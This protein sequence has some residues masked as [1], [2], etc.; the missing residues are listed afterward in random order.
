MSSIPPDGLSDD[1]V[2]EVLRRYRRVVVVGMS[3]S[4]DKPGHFVPQ[5]LREQGYEVVPV[6]PAAEE[7]AG[8]RC[9][10]SLREVPG[11]VGL[12]EVFRPSG[13]VPRVVA[14]AIE[15]G[16]RVVWLQEGIYHPAAVA[17]AREKGV[18]LVWNRCMM[19]EYKRLLSGA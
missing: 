11:E 4:P 14:E 15:R 1:E 9:Y 10:P 7:I 17:L 5:F 13:E 18:T 3:R 12:V 16:A 19:K 2:R 8:L 6:N